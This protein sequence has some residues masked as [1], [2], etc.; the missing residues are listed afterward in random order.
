[1][2][3]SQPSTT[4]TN[5]EKAITAAGPRPAPAEPERELI[6]APCEKPPSTIRSCGSESTN[7]AAAAYPSANVAGSG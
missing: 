2:S 1:M 7:P 6:T 5:P 4:G 3:S